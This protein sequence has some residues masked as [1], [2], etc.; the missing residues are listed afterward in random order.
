M[1]ESSGSSEGTQEVWRVERYQYTNPATGQTYPLPFVTDGQCHVMTT[2]HGPQ[3]DYFNYEEIWSDTKIEFAF[4]AGVVDPNTYQ[5][6]LGRALEK[7]PE[8]WIGSPRDAELLGH[9]LSNLRQALCMLRTGPTEE[10]RIGTVE[11]VLSRGWSRWTSFA[12]FQTE[13]RVR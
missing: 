6:F 8:L 5:V 9:L 1:S 2:G 4:D 12:G 3:T 11:F 7:H 10:Q 13:E